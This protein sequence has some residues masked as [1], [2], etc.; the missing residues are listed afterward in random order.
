MLL[1]VTLLLPSPAADFTFDIVVPQT[2]EHFRMRG[3]VGADGGSRVILF[4]RTHVP[5][6]RDIGGR[7]RFLEGAGRLRG[8]TPGGPSGTLPT[9]L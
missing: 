4:E 1:T 9:S 8:W 5:S 6:V 7:P 2:P 3:S